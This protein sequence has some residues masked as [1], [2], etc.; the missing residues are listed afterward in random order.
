[1]MLNDMN[2]L[3]VERLLREDKQHAIVAFMIS[4]STAHS[5]EL[6]IQIGHEA[7]VFTPKSYD[8]VWEGEHSHHLF[9]E[10]ELI[11]IL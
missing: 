11:L 3:F 8:R 7:S 9:P 5:G 2:V 4:V 6:A 1:M 10:I